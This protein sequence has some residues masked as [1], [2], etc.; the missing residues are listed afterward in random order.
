M[1]RQ[2]GV[3]TEPQVG[4]ASTRESEAAPRKEAEAAGRRVPLLVTLVVRAARAGVVAATA[5]PLVVG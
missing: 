1:T 2:T 5:A 4:P 3:A